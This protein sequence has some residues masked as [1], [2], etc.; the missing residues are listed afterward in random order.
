V[1]DTLD[2]TIEV[3]N[4]VEVLREE[5]GMFEVT[6]PY[7]HIFRVLCRRG[8]KMSVRQIVEPQLP[9]ANPGVIW[10]IRRV[11]SPAA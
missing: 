11:L 1:I 10:R 2:Q 3:E 7:G 4:P 5:D 6:S 9:V 8:T